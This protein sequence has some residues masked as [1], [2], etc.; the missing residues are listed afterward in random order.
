MLQVIR[1]WTQH[2]SKIDQE[3]RKIE[4]LICIWKPMTTGFIY[5][6]ID[7]RQQYGISVAESQTF[8]LTKRSSAAM[9]EEKR[10]SFTGYTCISFLLNGGNIHLNSLQYYP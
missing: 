5:V 9:S 7:L 3:K 1:R 4:Q 2:F 10:L 8:L 6:N